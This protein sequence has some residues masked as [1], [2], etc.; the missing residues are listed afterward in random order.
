[1]MTSM[2]TTESAYRLTNV[3]AGYADVYRGSLH[4]GSLRQRK[5][6]STRTGTMWFACN[7][8]GREFGSGYTRDEALGLFTT[9][10]GA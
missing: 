2:N 8:R 6:G 1:M 3:E 5:H 7:S 9:R 10:Y 4:M